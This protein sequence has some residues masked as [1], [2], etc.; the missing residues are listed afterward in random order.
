MHEEESDAIPIPETKPEVGGGVPPAVPDGG[1]DYEIE[2]WVI[3]YDPSLHFTREKLRQFTKTDQCYQNLLCLLKAAQDKGV[4]SIFQVNAA[5]AEAVAAFR[6]WR[7]LKRLES[8]SS[9]ME[10]EILK[11]Q[12]C[13]RL[14]VK[15]KMERSYRESGHMKDIRRA[16]NIKTLIHERKSVTQK[17]TFG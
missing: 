1:K 7:N 5:H 6:H 4:T 11:K 14:Y 16:L 10:V 3:A 8:K 15:A 9:S 13:Q 17:R 2:D 12:M